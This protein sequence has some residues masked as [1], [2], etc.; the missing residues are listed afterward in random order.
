MPGQPGAYSGETLD[1][2]LE[3]TAKKFVNSRQHFRVDRENKVVYVSK[4]FDWYGQKFLKDE[5]RAVSGNRPELY[6]LQWLDDETRKLLESG[7]Y[8]L[9]FIEWDWTLNERPKTKKSH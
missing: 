7:E 8:R 5:T 9:E 3:G 1:L 4:I 6:L 2:E